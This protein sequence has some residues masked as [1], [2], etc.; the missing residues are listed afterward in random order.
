MVAGFFYHMTQ[1]RYY[2]ENFN[3]LPLYVR[4]LFMVFIFI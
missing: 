2:H 3:Q 1:K 4:E